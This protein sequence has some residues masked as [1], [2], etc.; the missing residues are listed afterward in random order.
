MEASVVLK[1]AAKGNRV[2]VTE[3]YETR[4]K[5]L[6]VFCRSL[7]ENHDTADTAA[8]EAFTAVLEKLKSEKMN[9]MQQFDEAL[10]R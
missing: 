7:M 9:T 8:V 5:R 4:G 6:L 2:A 1:K 10:L 3:L